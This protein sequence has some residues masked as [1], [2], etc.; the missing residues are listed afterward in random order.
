MKKTFTKKDG[1]D[2]IT[3]DTMPISSLNLGNVNR[4]YVIE[5]GYSYVKG[6]LDS[7]FTKENTVV[8]YKTVLNLQYAFTKDGTSKS[9]VSKA[10]R[11]KNILKDIVTRQIPVVEISRQEAESSIKNI[12]E[13]GISMRNNKDYVIGVASYIK[14]KLGYDVKVMTDSSKV[15]QFSLDQNAF[16]HDLERR[17]KNKKK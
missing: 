13:E 15:A 7:Q 14:N 6:N 5:S 2:S 3:V 10:N 12:P 1:S 16:A 17:G 11:A 4:V 9:D 8:P